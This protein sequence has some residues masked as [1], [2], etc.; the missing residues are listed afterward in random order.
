MNPRLTIAA[1]GLV[2]LL[3]GCATT[4]PADPRQDQAPAPSPSSDQ[5]HAA[6]RREFTSRIQNDGYHTQIVAGELMLLP[7]SR[8]LQ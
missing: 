8:D 2:L 5:Q 7:G 6:A 4:A 1:I 3:C